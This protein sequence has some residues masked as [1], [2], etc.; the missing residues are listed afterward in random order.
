MQKMIVRIVK[1]L[2]IVTLLI[3]LSILVDCS[4]P[5]T[6]GV[7]R[8]LGAV[9]NP[10][11]CGAAG[12]ARIIA[13]AAESN[14]ANFG[15]DLPNWDDNPFPVSQPAIITSPTNTG[16]GTTA[17]LQSGP[18]SPG[19][20]ANPMPSGL[21]INF[22]KEIP[23]WNFGGKVKGMIDCEPHT[24]VT[25]L[26]FTIAGMSAYRLLVLDKKQNTVKLNSGAQ[27]TTQSQENTSNDSSSIDWKG[28]MGLVL[29]TGLIFNRYITSQVSGF[30]WPVNQ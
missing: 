3:S 16:A 11:D 19:S 25:F 27:P 13:G 26:G 22:P 6:D 29:G 10:A 7:A 20:G 18:L 9:G 28:Y 17:P 2:S 12:V 23:Y 15:A 14:A 5:P 21:K 24:L 4:A 8:V 30:M 1:K